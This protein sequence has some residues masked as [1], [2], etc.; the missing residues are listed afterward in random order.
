MSSHADFAHE[1][2]ALLHRLLAV[3]CDNSPKGSIDAPIRG[4]V[5]ALN[6]D[7]R[8]VTTS[9]CSGRIS[10]FA[11]TTAPPAAE[12]ATDETNGIAN[13]SAEGANSTA[14]TATATP[15]ATGSSGAKGGG[16]GGAG[17]WLLASHDPITPG[18]L[19]KAL[20]HSAEDE[21]VTLKHEVEQS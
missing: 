15:G 13:E 2:K 9:S 7:P 5:D 20:L 19:R 3:G 1:K 11:S 21:D 4:L 8:F 16:K 6:A 17:R 10:L 12:T 18:T 14:R